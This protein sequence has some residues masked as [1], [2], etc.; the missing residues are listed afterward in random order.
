MDRRPR[1][2]PDSLARRVAAT[3]DATAFVTADRRVTYADLDHASEQVAAALTAD[4]IKP[5]SRVAHLGRESERYY[6]VLLGCAKAH[7]VLVPV[8][9][10]LTAP[11]TGHILGDSEAQ[12]VFCDRE[13]A[14]SGIP[15]GTAARVLALDDAGPDGY[16]AW[17]EA[18]PCRTDAAP[19]AGPDDPVVQM[20]TSG[21][22]GLPKGVVLAHRSFF[23]VRHALADAGLDWID[24]R[25]DDIT[26]L[27]VPGFH[28][29]GLWWAAQ[30][31]DEGVPVVLMP[32]F[33][34]GAALR[35]IREHAVTT[36]CMVPAMLRAVLGEP[37]TAAA[38]FARIRKVVYGGSPMPEALLARCV[39]VM[40]CEFAQIY[41]L[42]ETGNTAVCLPPRDHAPGA[43][44]LRAA[45]RP[46]PGFAVKV[47][48]DD[49]RALAP[50]EIGEVWLRSPARMLGYWHRPD[51]DAETLV[52]DWIRTG[53]A[54]F[55]DADGYVHLHDRVK[56]MIISAGENIYPAEIENALAAHP[57]VADAAV[58]G[59]PDDRWGEAV[60][61]FV[62]A[63]DPGSP[64]AP[65][66]LS[67]FLR[68]R[69]A[70]FKLPARYVF[71]ESV[72]RNPSG[73]ALR[74]ELRAPYWR[75]RERN[76]N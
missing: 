62:V 74:R 66:D 43:P 3:P 35:A 21:T 32:A 38:D 1:T 25:A 15:A 30:A 18:A 19:P 71:V 5:G 29:G 4:G 45:G 64:P 6:E 9:W 11:E 23:A 56:D 33:T 65:A 75:D 7:V 60:H 22:T 10:R 55:L 28:I 61:A 39:E 46:Y 36:L 40:G 63:A 57:G 17:K 20:Y 52:G 58:I 8:N 49:E 26:L 14:D 16:Q 69:L 31:L 24:W 51:A 73:K 50:G 27:S 37:G 72:P 12:L 47:V 34:P 76:V 53:D 70:P 44:R 13:F 54:G 42:T 48:G 68:G 2:L 67:R 59:V 41:G